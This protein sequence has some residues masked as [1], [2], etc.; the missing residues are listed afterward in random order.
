MLYR[1]NACCKTAD[2][3][4]HGYF[5]QMHFAKLNAAERFLYHISDNLFTDCDVAE[6]ILASLRFLRVEFFQVLANQFGLRA[7]ARFR[8]NSTT[9]PPEPAALVH[10]C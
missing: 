2:D 9:P 7:A 3:C 8:T 5:R 4:V 10:L 6:R 1:R